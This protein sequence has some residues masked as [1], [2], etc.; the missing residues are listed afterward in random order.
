MLETIPC[1]ACEEGVME[2]ATIKR[3]GGALPAVGLC[4]A[5]GGV[6]GGVLGLKAG[7]EMIGAAAWAGAASQGLSQQLLGVVVMAAAGMAGLP[8]FVAGLVFMEVRPVWRCHDC[9]SVIDRA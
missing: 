4:L 9:G 3:F 5:A 6:L 1:R 7:W 8:A 2:R